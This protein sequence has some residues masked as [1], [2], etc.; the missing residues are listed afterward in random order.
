MKVPVFIFLLLFYVDCSAQNLLLNGSFEDVNTC[1]EYNIECAPEAWISSDN[2]FDNYFKDAGRAHTGQYCLAIEAGHVTRP[3][4]RTFLR[5]Q[6]IC[7]LKKGNRYRLEFF[8]KSFHPILD[9]IGVYFGSM[10]PLLERK[11]IYRLAPTLFLKDGANNFIRDS[12]WQ[13]A[14]LDYT[15]TG[16]EVYITI[17]NFSRNDISGSTGLR[18]EN[19]FF[20]F[21]DDVSFKPLD[22]NERLCDNWQQVKEDIY[23][24]NERHQYLDRVLRMRR[25]DSLYR[26]L[27]LSPTTVVVAD[28]LLLP[29]VLFASGK[30]DLR[31]ESLPLLDSFCRSMQGKIIDSLVIEGHADNTG[32]IALNER[33]SIERAQSVADQLL[34]CQ[35]LANKSIIMRGWGSRLPV[36]PNDTPANRQRNRR[37]V[38]MVY[39]RE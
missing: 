3:Y 26:I 9:S 39:F 8:I 14:V 33:L 7:R 37:V 30:K 31:K 23:D 38:L 15:A 6:L 4:E 17:A 5:S 11:P 32:S 34:S 36:A 22:P 10:D 2:G 20:A 12:S 13:K 28:T 19:H 35:P 24:Q 16:K 25:N 21:I 18:R 27:T 29:D 1:T